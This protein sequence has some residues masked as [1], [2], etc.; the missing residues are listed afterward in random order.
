MIVI[1]DLHWRVDTPS[2]RREENYAKDVLRPKM[3]WIIDSYPTD[4]IVIAGDVFHRPSDMA[5]TFDLMEFLHHNNHTLYAVRGQHDMVNHNEAEVHTGFN[6]LALSGLLKPIDNE[7]HINGHCVNG[8]NWGDTVAVSAN[9][10]ILVAHVCLAQAND[11]IPNSTPVKS[12][13]TEAMEK[14]YRYVFTGDNHQR[15]TYGD[16]LFNAGCFH[17]MTQDLRD[18][19]PGFWLFNDMSAPPTIVEIACNDVKVNEAYV[20]GAERQKVVASAKFA[21]ALSSAQRKPGATFI[22]SLK[23]SMAQAEAGVAAILQE[24]VTNCEGVHT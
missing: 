6:I 4:D 5:A 12:F 16:T 23:E 10:R 11:N 20:K 15:F 22:D 19:S 8:V 21:E 17:R 1:S 7:T 13:A 14:G 24:I 2:W 9:S 18:Q 3:Q